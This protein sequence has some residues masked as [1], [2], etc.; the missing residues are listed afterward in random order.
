[1]MT[2]YVEVSIKDGPV[3]I[4]TLF[5]AGAEN[6][7]PLWDEIVGHETFPATKEAAF[8]QLDLRKPVHR[9]DEVLK[10]EEHLK[11]CLSA[12]SHVWHFAGGT[13]LIYESSRR[14]K[15]PRYISNAERIE[16]ELLAM[17]GNKKV[18]CGAAMSWKTI[19]GYRDMPLTLAANLCR[20]AASN[21]PLKKLFKYHY[22][23]LTDNDKWF[24]HIYK[25]RDTLCEALGKQDNVRSTLGIS[26]S[27]WKEFGRI[28]DNYD[29]RHPGIGVRNVTVPKAA[30]ATTKEMA[31]LWILAY[32]QYLGLSAA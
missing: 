32:L 24:V 2:K 17:Q 7:V 13:L 16:E 26:S 1:M 19:G 25:V 11:L 4:D 20:A 30:V 22:E 8:Y 3:E 10:A 9:A 14:E 5:G 23:G 12:L 28:L 31:R 27:D 18:Y 15:S 6:K 29:L 21:A